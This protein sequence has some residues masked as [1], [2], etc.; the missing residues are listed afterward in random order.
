MKKLTILLLLAIAVA[1]TSAAHAWTFDVI[2]KTCF[3]DK[4]TYACPEAYSK[5]T[6]TEATVFYK[7]GVRAVFSG[8]DY[9]KELTKESGISFFIPS[10]WEARVKYWKCAYSGVHSVEG[11]HWIWVSSSSGPTIPEETFTLMVR[12]Y[13]D[14]GPGPA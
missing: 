2:A 9:D 12:Q 10:S 5:V 8:P 6:F 11:R 3:H 1:G 14:C 13:C 7:V 4:K